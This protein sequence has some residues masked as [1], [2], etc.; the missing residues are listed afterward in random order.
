MF[1]P[2]IGFNKRIYGS[3]CPKRPVK[4][5]KR[6]VFFGSYEGF[7]FIAAPILNY[8]LPKT[9]FFQSSTYRQKVFYRWFLANGEWSNS[10]I[11][12]HLSSAEIFG[13]LYGSISEPWRCWQTVPTLRCR[14]V[15]LARSFLYQQLDVILSNLKVETA[16]SRIAT[17]RQQC[18]VRGSIF[19][20]LF[21]SRI[22]FLRR[23][24][25]SI[26]PDSEFETQFLPGTRLGLRCLF[27]ELQMKS[28]TWNF[29]V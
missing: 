12:W 25:V 24:E 27:S 10:R 29:W 19:C 2:H 21:E 18:A 6:L 15:P 13:I 14:G 8:S 17:S 4:F 11:P 1:I 26:Q 3:W 7:A 22:L 20:A 28:I 5:S 16:A 23:N 9:N